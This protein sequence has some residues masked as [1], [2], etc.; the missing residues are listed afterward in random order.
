MRRRNF[1]ALLVLTALG[2]GRTALAQSRRPPFIVVLSPYGETKDSVFNPI[3]RRDFDQ[4]LKDLG[5]ID[6]S[7]IR[8]N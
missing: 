3:F 6:A 4:A 7:N 2:K 8:I 5:W 1:I